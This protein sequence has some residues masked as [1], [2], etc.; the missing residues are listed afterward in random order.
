MR[1]LI[2]RN[3]LTGAECWYEYDSLNDTAVITHEQ[4][5]GEILE[6]NVISQNDDDKTKRGIKG[7]WWKYASIP[8]I[9][10]LKWK[11]EKGID[12]FDKNHRNA[13]F[14]LLNDPEYR[15]LKTTAKHHE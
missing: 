5:V 8:N 14:K 12:I 4:D 13:M 11:Q 6:R 15:F 9:V 2:D 3:P 10:W 1:R 7:D